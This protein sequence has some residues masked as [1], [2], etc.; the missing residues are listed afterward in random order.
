MKAAIHIESLSKSYRTP[1]RRQLVAAVR[2]LNLTVAQGEAFGFVGPNGAG[3]STT[4]RMLTGVLLPTQGSASLFGVGIADP[5]SR[6]GIGYVPENPYLNDCLTPLEV[7]QMSMRLHGVKVV[8]EYAHCMYWL[9]R[10]DLAAASKKYLRSLSKGMVQRVALAQAMCIQPRML[11]LDEPLSG[12]DPL[13]RRDVVNLL[14]EYKREGGTLFFTSHV[15]HDVERLADRFGLIKGGQLLTISSP[16]GLAIDEQPFTVRYVGSASINGAHLE[17][18]GRWCAEVSGKSVW[19]VLEQVR[20]Q[21]GKLLE[22]KPAL[23]L[24]KV[25]LSFIDE[26]AP[27]VP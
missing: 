4:I 22:V 25:F 27:V 11:I 20:E 26:A 6:R 21:G 13:G 3:K 9:E 24:E 19:A 23:N 8:N 12:L 16:A 17:A 18:E 1:W 7:L 2:E 5:Q 14:A 10:L 15:L